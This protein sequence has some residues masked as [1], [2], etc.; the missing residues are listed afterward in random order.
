MTRK[1]FRNHDWITEN[2]RDNKGRGRKRRPPL[3]FVL[4]VNYLEKGQSRIRIIL[5]DVA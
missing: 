1:A 2:R 5:S 3:G 4:Q